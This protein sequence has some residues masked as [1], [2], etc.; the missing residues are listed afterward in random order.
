MP[1]SNPTTTPVSA[2]PN[3]ESIVV[4]TDASYPPYEFKNEK[5]A[6]V[7]FDVDLMNAVAQRAGINITV[8]SKS[9]ENILAG[10]NTDAHDVGMST[11]ARNPERENAYELSATYAYGKDVIVTTPDNT[12]IKTFDDLK[13]VKVATETDTFSAEDLT[14]LQG[15]NNPNLVLTKTNYLALQQLAQGKVDAVLA[16]QGVMQYHLKSIGNKKFRFTGEGNY[17]VPYEMVWLAKKGNKTLIEK[18][19]KGLAEVVADG[20]YAK[21]YEQWFG[22]APTPEQLPKVGVPTSASAVQ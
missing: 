6:I 15:E 17:F 19:N 1:A 4:A 20:T 21:I 12:S 3:A 7:G 2:D 16:E 11:I 14:K 9:F 8:I 18:L 10:V 22:V 13:N 5:G